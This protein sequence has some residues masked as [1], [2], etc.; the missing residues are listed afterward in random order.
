MRH[1]FFDGALLTMFMCVS[2]ASDKNGKHIDFSHVECNG[3]DID[4]ERRCMG[5]RFG[6]GNTKVR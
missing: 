2:A 3:N 1:R 6:M 4:C 5:G